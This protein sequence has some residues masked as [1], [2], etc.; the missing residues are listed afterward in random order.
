MRQI[1][2]RRSLQNLLWVAGGLLMAGAVIGLYK[3][4]FH[5][6]FATDYAPVE[7]R[8][9][10]LSTTDNDGGLP[11]RVAVAA[12]TDDGLVGRKRVAP[13]RLHGCK[14]GDRIA[15]SRKG[16]DLKLSPSPCR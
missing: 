8:I 9:T 7:A 15:A 10:G 6:E 2:H 4:R 14:V 16:T 13:S 11:P 1:L 12:M 5:R 3:L